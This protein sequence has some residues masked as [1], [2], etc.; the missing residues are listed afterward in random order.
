MTIERAMAFKRT[1]SRIRNTSD[2]LYSGI[3]K[4]IISNY[5]YLTSSDV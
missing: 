4:S 3:L 1:L 5:A 2:N